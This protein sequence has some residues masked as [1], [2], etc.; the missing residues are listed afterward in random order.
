MLPQ[1]RSIAENSDQF[2]TKGRIVTG[3]LQDFANEIRAFS[4]EQRCD[5][6]KCRG[7]T[8]SLEGMYILVAAKATATVTWGAALETGL[9]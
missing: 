5:N 4:K 6:L 8:F 9:F 1:K 7:K 2:P 3:L